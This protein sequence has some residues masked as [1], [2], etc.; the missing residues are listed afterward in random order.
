M[1]VMVVDDEQDIQ[2]LFRQQFRREIKQGIIKLYFALSAE[3]ALEYLQDNVSAHLVLI[4]ADINMPGINGLE[5]L[6]IIKQRYPHL[7][8][9]IITAYCDEH[10]FRVARQYGADDYIEKP[11]VFDHLK[12]KI[13]KL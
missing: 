10:N 4:L 3:E 5:L 8:V 12:E 9:F 13:L 11:V 6:K 1:N 2:L 7:K